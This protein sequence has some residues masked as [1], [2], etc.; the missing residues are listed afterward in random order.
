MIQNKYIQ[1]LLQQTALNEIQVAIRK[2]NLF[3]IRYSVI[4]VKSVN[5]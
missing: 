5:L 3:G 1:Y 2:R 4:D